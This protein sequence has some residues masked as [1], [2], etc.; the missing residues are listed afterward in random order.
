MLSRGKL[1]PPTNTVLLGLIM[2]IVYRYNVCIFA[3]GQ[4]GSGKSY[5][6]MGKLDSSDRG[7]IPRVRERERER[8][9]ERGGRGKEMKGEERILWVRNEAIYSL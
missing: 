5:T 7:I 2:Y 9:I 3:Y 1:H 4:T 6:M 8:N